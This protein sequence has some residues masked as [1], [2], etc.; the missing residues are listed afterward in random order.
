MCASVS[1]RQRKRALVLWV[2][3]TGPLEKEFR[4]LNVDY[5]QNFVK[6]LTAATERFTKRTRRFSVTLS[7]VECLATFHARK[8]IPA[9]IPYNP[10]HQ[11][12]NVNTQNAVFR[13]FSNN[14]VS[15][16]ILPLRVP[17]TT[18]KPELKKRVIRIVCTRRDKRT[19]VRVVPD[20]P[21]LL[22]AD[23]GASRSVAG[24]QLN[25][26]DKPNSISCPRFH[27]RVSRCRFAGLSFSPLLP[28]EPRGS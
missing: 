5:D 20:I 8:N 22:L 7:S 18:R 6:T 15:P 19:Y 4:F 28:S 27:C 11:L 24:K 14:R 1:V 17:K 3:S 26:R 23:A 21:K 12:L 13:V 2:H 25:Y 9:P 10:H 16:V